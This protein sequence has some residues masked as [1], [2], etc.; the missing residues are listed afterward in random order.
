MKWR[1][2]KSGRLTR[3][4]FKLS[5]S[6]RVGIE[7]GSR[8]RHFRPPTFGLRRPANGLGYLG[9]ARVGAFSLREDF[10]TRLAPLSLLRDRLKNIGE[11]EAVD[12]RVV[13]NRVNDHISTVCSINHISVTYTHTY[14][15]LGLSQELQNLGCICSN[16]HSWRFPIKSIPYTPFGRTTTN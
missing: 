12:L 8:S 9:S 4:K 7:T 16:P 1:R 3:G 14:S 2:G 13:S 11:N 6:A 5:A 15:P 10:D